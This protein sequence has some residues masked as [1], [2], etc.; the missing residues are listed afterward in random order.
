MAV[1]NI[2]KAK[3]AAKKTTPN[4]VVTR[5]HLKQLTGMQKRYVDILHSMASPGK[6]KA[7][8]LAGYKSTGKIGNVEAQ[9]TLNLPHVKA[10]YDSLR[11]RATEKAQRTSDEIIAELEKI[12]FS[13]MRDKLKVR[14]LELL[15]RRFGLFPNKT[16]LSGISGKPIPVSIVDYRKIDLENIKPD[17]RTTPDNTK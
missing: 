17:V 16:E 8:S 2:T 9:R 14:C 1:K 11:Q 7:F 3:R 15:G 12:A 6:F 10:Y 13:S 4:K 5:P